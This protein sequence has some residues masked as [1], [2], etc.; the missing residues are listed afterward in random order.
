M[1]RTEHKLKCQCG[2]EGSII[3]KENDQPYSANY[4]SYSLVGFNG[5]SFTSHDYLS[6]NVVLE[7][8]HPICPNCGTLQK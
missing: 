8:L 1:T 7:K 4:E 5:D 3:M 2:H 6:W